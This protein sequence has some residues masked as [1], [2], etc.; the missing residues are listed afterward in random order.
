VSK[1]WIRIQL[2]TFHQ[3]TFH[4]IFKSKANYILILNL[5]TKFGIIYKERG[6]A[7]FIILAFESNELLNYISLIS[8]LKKKS[9]FNAKKL[10]IMK[11][12]RQ[13]KVCE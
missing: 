12:T 2:Y 7:C 9:K 1:N 3:I 8:D 11:F 10:K 6:V 13:S 5:K 4:F